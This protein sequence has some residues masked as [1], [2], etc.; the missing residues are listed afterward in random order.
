[1]ETFLDLVLTVWFGSASKLIII[2][3]VS[4]M[5]GYFFL[6]P[7]CAVKRWWAF[8]PYAGGY[9]FAKCADREFEG[10]VL[11]VGGVALTVISL[12]LNFFRPRKDV[13]FYILVSLGVAVALILLLYKLRVF[14]GICRV[15]E[16]RRWWLI[17]WFLLE[18]P[19]AI[20]WGLRKTFQPLYTV[21]EMM[22]EVATIVSGARVRTLDQGLT[23][24]INER[25]APDIYR[26][27]YLLKDIHLSIEPGKMV[28]L[29][30]GSG[31]G[32]TS[33]IKTINGYER[34]DA[35]VLLNGTNVHKYRK[36]MLYGIGYVPQESR[37]RDRDTVRHTLLD[38]ATLRLP[39]DMNM[40]DRRKLVKDV[41][42]VFSL[43]SVKNVLVRELSQGQKKR[44]SI[45]MEFMADPLLFILDGPDMGLDGAVTRDLME[46][47]RHMADEG[48]IIIVATDCPDRA[49]DLFDD[50]I[51]LAKD[52]NRT[53]RLAF[54][55]SVEET[56]AFFGMENM[57]KI[58][59]AVSHKEDGG[60]GRADE[61]INKFVEV[62]NA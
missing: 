1:M 27:R 30:G 48:K 2:Y 55:G 24:N 14:I 62:L 19:T 17:P 10:R 33:F 4:I 38:A 53:G 11:F 15:F 42:E 23:V 28:L 47:L 59:R 5:A 60:D 40:D 61:F 41:M 34:G 57:E 50:V 43:T 29:L 49:I 13:V 7:K 21:E 46:Q 20:L 56:K 31:S 3:Q 6:F 25:K 36:Q 9:Q 54:Y 51:V 52:A 37:I 45:A 44:L 26:R 22:K 12:V 39:L 8:I 58:M 35:E 32:R 18:G 16:R